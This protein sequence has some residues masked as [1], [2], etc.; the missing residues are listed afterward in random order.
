MSSLHGNDFNLLLCL[1]QIYFPDLS[2]NVV[3]D[4]YLVKYTG[5]FFCNFFYCF[6]PRKSS[7]L[8]GTPRVS[9]SLDPQLGPLLQ[10]T[11]ECEKEPGKGLTRRKP[12]CSLPRNVA[13]VKL[14]FYLYD[15]ENVSKTP[16]KSSVKR[17]ITHTEAS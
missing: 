14:D 16:D 6:V 9:L 3:H 8:R 15:E 5:L 17:H 1:Q 4:F 10:Q 2:Y 13:L 12:V 7:S 11:Y